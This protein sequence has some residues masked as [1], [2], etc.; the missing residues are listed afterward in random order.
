MLCVCNG[1]CKRSAGTCYHEEIVEECIEIGEVYCYGYEEASE[2]VELHFFLKGIE[3]DG[4][5]D[6]LLSD[7]IPSSFFVNM[8]NNFSMFG[9][10]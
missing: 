6:T 4:A 1:Q 9:F 10:S 5:R 2:R 3:R 7:W 8:V